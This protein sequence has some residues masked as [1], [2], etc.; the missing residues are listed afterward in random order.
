M[1]DGGGRRAVSL[2]NKE[3]SLKRKKRTW[4][5][6]VGR[7]EGMM[8][9]W[10]EWQKE[11]T[12]NK[13]SREAVKWSWRWLTLTLYLCVFLFLFF[14]PSCMHF[15]LHSDSYILYKSAFFCWLSLSQPHISLWVMFRTVAWQNET[16]CSSK[17]PRNKVFQFLLEINIFW[18]CYCICVCKIYCVLVHTLLRH[19]Q[20]LYYWMCI[21]V[22]F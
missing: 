3:L 21:F 11:M 15:I 2:N 20:C 13:W 10:T 1:H 8:G 22:C 4:D 14:P 18:A 16:V 9:R 6:S 7:Q 12:A 19:I 17:M 5:R